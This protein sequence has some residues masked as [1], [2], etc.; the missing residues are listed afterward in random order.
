MIVPSIA[1]LI[2]REHLYKP[3]QGNVLTLG[4]QTIDMSFDEVIELFK[5]EGYTPPKNI[6]NEA[7]ITYDKRTRHIGDETNFITDT[8]FFELLGI[9]NIVAMDVSKYESAEIIH[10]LN[11][12]VPKE[13]Y[14]NFDFIIDGGTFDHIFDIKT[15]F[16]NVVKMLKDGGRVLQWNAASNFTGTVYTSFGPDLFYDYYVVNKFIDCK[17]Y[18]VEVDSISQRNDWDFYEFKG[19]EGFS[20]FKSNNIQ[21]ILVLAEKGPVST[22]NL[23]PVQ[24]HYRDAN[25]WRPYN[26]SKKIIQS[27][28]RPFF[29]KT[30]VNNKLPTRK[31]NLKPIFIMYIEKIKEKGL[32]WCINKFISNRKKEKILKGY[33]YIGK[34]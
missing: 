17:V 20:H 32:V 15:A 12:P 14:N 30:P 4:R 11:N 21:M 24:S 28:L 26:E 5:Q 19:D 13:L 27:S 31:H 25:L 23:M 8:L 10:D 2:I 16:E 34:I 18:V 7:T 22:S 6:I 33:R 1:R 9:K 3:I 29:T